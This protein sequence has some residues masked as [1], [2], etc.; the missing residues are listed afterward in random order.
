M[1]LPEHLSFLP[2]LLRLAL[3]IAAQSLMMTVLN[4]V[5]TVMVGRLGEVE[6]A[7]IAL[8]NQIFFLLMLFLLGVGSGGA[9]FA[10][11]YWGQGDVAGVRKALAVSLRVALG[12]ALLFSAGAIGA[13]RLLL[14]AFTED[15]RVIAVGVPYLR[16]V[17]SSYL[18]TAASA[19]FAHSLRSIGDTKLPMYASIL[20]ISVN[21]VGNYVLIFGAFGLPALGV[22][23]AAVSTALARA[24]ELGLIL[25]VVYRR[26]GPIAA[27]PAE[28]L[29]RDR[30]FARRYLA[31]SAPVI[32]NEVLWSTGFVMYA[33]VFGRMGTAYLAAY[34]IADTVGRLMLVF[35]IGTGQAS[36]VLIGNTI[37]RGEQ[38]E[39]ERMGRTLLRLVPLVSAAVGVLVFFLIAPLVPG[40]F[41][42]P[43]ATRALVQRF[44]R[45]FAV[46]IVAK[47]GN[48]HVI[49]G[50][51]RGGGD[52]RYALAIDIAPLWL[53]GVPLAVVTGLVLGLPAPLVY[54]C[55]MLE[56]A[57]RFL[58]GW[59]RVH[60]GRWVTDVTREELA[61][62]NPPNG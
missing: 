34:N 46:L 58:L 31:R 43:E 45:L 42:I 35:F 41:A 3:P 19:T 22:T 24:L 15:A 12:G 49:V 17:G 39:A 57:T 56:E 8:G 54:G 37:G 61:I 59:A 52:T 27:R 6:I 9:V 4:L 25:T 36:A 30:V 44:L 38:V 2:R 60:S 48:I 40:L 50:I 1:K 53:I 10:A 55:L 16:I 11:Q 62:I 23:G 21:I 47:A 32:F 5:D 14:S 13:P 20:S 29:Q 28:L 51:L 18:F 26:K 33:L 7:A